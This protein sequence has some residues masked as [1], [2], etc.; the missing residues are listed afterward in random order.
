MARG[1]G[2]GRHERGDA[3]VTSDISRARIQSLM[4]TM[5]ATVES[6]SG[7]CNAGYVAGD[8]IVV[9]R[10]TG[11]IDK[12]RSASLC[13]WALGSL[14]SS[15]CRVPDGETISVSCPDPATGRGGNVIF[16]LKTE[17]ANAKA[18]DRSE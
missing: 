2:Q 9:V 11:C 12:D 7:K 17:E 13:I 16:S 3:F 1:S 14:L 10:D 8:R 4:R 5:T 15:M 18:E 6:V